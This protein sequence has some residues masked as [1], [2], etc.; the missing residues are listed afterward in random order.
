MTETLTW[1]PFCTNQP[2]FL[3]SCILS[4]LIL[5]NQAYS[6]GRFISTCKTWIEPA[7]H[8]IS[9]TLPPLHHCNS[10]GRSAAV[11][12]FH[13]CISRASRHGDCRVTAPKLLEP[14]KRHSDYYGACLKVTVV[15]RWKPLMM[16]I[17]AINVQWCYQWAH[18]FSVTVS[19]YS[20]FNINV[21]NIKHLSAL[22]MVKP[23]HCQSGTP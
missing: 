3:S 18:V 22:N 21:P 7:T 9:V 6:H 16:K 23:E 10:R 13:C 5:I 8:C 11:H 12:L 4:A 17:W 1:K 19:S 20:T 2:L 14:G 15:V